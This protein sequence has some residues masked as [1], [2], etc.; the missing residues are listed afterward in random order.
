ML[1]LKVNFLRKRGISSL[2]SSTRSSPTQI[3]TGRRQIP[4]LGE[5]EIP[6]RKVCSATR[7][8]NRVQPIIQSAKFSRAPMKALY[9]SWVS[10][11]YDT[12][13][14]I[15]GARVAQTPWS[16]NRYGWSHR[17]VE[18]RPESWRSPTWTWW[19]SRRLVSLKVINFPETKISATIVFNLHA[20]GNFFRST[21]VYSFWN[22]R[23][24]SKTASSPGN[25]TNACFLETPRLSSK[26][27]SISVTMYFVPQEK[28]SFR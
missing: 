8:T 26:I 27:L 16:F 7:A 2:N 15:R 13:A 28:Q 4:R 20:P 12:G 18:A 25:F 3:T 10:V 6:L 19:G 11:R 21:E 23:S 17:W 1:P 9:T 22:W 24:W 14:F 5:Y